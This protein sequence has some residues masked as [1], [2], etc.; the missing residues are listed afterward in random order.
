[1]KINMT[2]KSK[3]YQIKTKMEQEQWLQLKML[4]LV[5]SGEER[6]LLFGPGIKI[7][8]WRESTGLGGFSRWGQGGGGERNILGCKRNFS[9]ISQ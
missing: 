5:F 1:M 6:W 9:P 2:C 8:C 7:W 4:F 3:E